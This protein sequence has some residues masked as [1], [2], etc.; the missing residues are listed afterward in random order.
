MPCYAYSFE[1]RRPGEFDAARARGQGIPLPFWRRLQNGETVT[2]E[3][4]RVFEPGMVL[5]PERRGIKVSY[6]TDSRP[7]KAMRSLFLGSDLLVCEGM[8]G[9]DAER[10]N[11]AGMMHMVFSEAARL[12]RAAGAGEL[13]LTHF[14]PAMPNP[15]DYVGEARKFFANSRAGRDLMATTIAFRDEAPG[16]APGA[17]PAAE[18]GEAMGGAPADAPGEAPADALGDAPADAPGE[19]PAGG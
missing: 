14:S 16:E 7:T 2:G 10:E 8:Y 15:G 6:C 17:A 11:A 12:A 4:G 19:A 5:G 1:V 9:A 13:W 18:A 3:D